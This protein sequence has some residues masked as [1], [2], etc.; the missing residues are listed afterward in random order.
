V[1]I[2]TVAPAAKLD[3]VGS[4]MIRGSTFNFTAANQTASYIFTT[5]TTNDYVNFANVDIGGQGI[6]TAYLRWTRDGGFGRSFSVHT[7]DSGG[8]SRLALV[9]TPS[10]NV[11]IGTDDAQ[12]KLTV[13]NG[14][15][16]IRSSNYL[17]TRSL[18]FGNPAR[19]ND[20]AYLKYVGNGDFT[21]SLRLGVVTSQANIPATD[22]LCVAGTGNVGIGT[23]NP[24]SHLEVYGPG[25]FIAVQQPNPG[26]TG[27]RFGDGGT[28]RGSIFVNGISGEMRHE[29][30][31]GGLGGFYAF[32]NAGQ[33]HLHIAASG[34]VG[35]GQNPSQ[36]NVFASRCTVR[37]DQNAI[38]RQ[39]IRNENLGS[40]AG[41]EYSLN[42]AGNSWTLGMGSV[43]NNANAFYI[44]VDVTS[45][46]AAS[47]PLVILTNGFVGI[48][49]TDP[50]C[51]LHVEVPGGANGLH[52]RSPGLGHT[53][54]PFSDGRNYLRGSCI[55]ADVVPTELVGI[56]THG[57][58]AKLHVVSA[59]GTDSAR[60]SDSAN[61][62]LS[63]GRIPGA[64]G[65]LI[66]GT[67]NSALALGTNDAERMRITTL[68]QV[69]IA[70]TTPGY[71]LSLG[72]MLGDKLAVYDFSS[73]FY[74]FGVDSGRMYTKAA[75]TECMT[76]VD[77][78]H[79]G[80]GTTT[81]TCRLDVAGDVRASGFVIASG[82]A[83][84]T[85]SDINANRS[86]TWKNTTSGEVR[87]WV[88]DGGVLLKSPAYS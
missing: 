86:L 73:T 59:E 3:V 58:V 16:A 10:A 9:A 32:Y 22:I 53:W 84:P 39:L 34:A 65:G 78:G 1:G 8:V 76:W 28:T 75:N 12:S 77:T 88:N 37:Q 60:F 57:P 23:T 18:G 66:S 81:P 83:D 68:G 38:T 44:G 43:A 51:R 82:A 11:G 5:G 42:A 24:Q 25:A 48:G 30:G 17:E 69:G 62:T 35:I 20:A 14:D 52:I 29:A 67:T 26:V 61:Y 2:G 71:L 74:G 45:G 80:I 46:V 70:T 33:E 13:A 47:K 6:D 55:I 31:N 72:A 36:Y 4:T 85:V 27:L 54:L 79:V 40:A 56:G 50:L 19:A 87:H 64:T 41:A 49:T 15:V 63:I 21:G 7:C